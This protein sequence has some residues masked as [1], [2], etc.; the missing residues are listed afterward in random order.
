MIGNNQDVLG[1]NNNATLQ[2]QQME[3]G[4][5]YAVCRNDESN[6][7]V[8][9]SQHFGQSCD[10]GKK[11]DRSDRCDHD[12]SLS[13][14][15]SSRLSR[16]EEVSSEVNLAH[17]EVSNGVSGNV[18]TVVKERNHVSHDRSGREV[19]DRNS[20]TDLQ[21][22]NDTI[23][24]SIDMENG[25]HSK[26]E[27]VIILAELLLDSYNND[28]DDDDGDKILDANKTGCDFIGDDKKREL[29]LT[30]RHS[31]ASHQ[32]RSRCLVSSCP[33]TPD[34]SKPIYKT[35]EN[36]V[37]RR[38]E[39]VESN[40][41][42]VMVMAPYV[43]QSQ[44][45]DGNGP[46]FIDCH[47]LMCEPQQ[48]HDQNNNHSPEESNDDDE[49]ESSLTAMISAEDLGTYVDVDRNYVMRKRD[50]T[51]CHEICD[52][53][54]NDTSNDTCDQSYVR[55]GDRNGGSVDGTGTPR[56]S[57]HPKT[58]VRLL[59]NDT[60]GKDVMLAA[61]H[62]ES[63]V[64]ESVPL[65]Y[66]SKVDLGNKVHNSKPDEAYTTDDNNNLSGI[67]TEEGYVP[68]KGKVVVFDDYYKMNGSYCDSQ[69]IKIDKK[70][71]CRISEGK[72]ACSTQTNQAMAASNTKSITTEVCTPAPRRALRKP[73]EQCKKSKKLSILKTS[74]VTDAYSR[75]GYELKQVL[76]SLALDF[77]L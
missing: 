34:G 10:I 46:I 75:P 58:L 24:K 57:H 5:D 47:M 66:F 2:Q 18:E 30:T 14:E 65:G 67:K 26:D 31:D 15:L 59:E 1:D 64:D 76:P 54:C 61:L 38:L 40:S 3:L 43:L 12:G 6:S 52:Q 73:S 20:S 22:D 25:C 41:S 51:I 60:F 53:T 48:D 32:D 55:L 16:E 70:N 69:Q 28:D 7:V 23:V 11:E 21:E 27:D 13:N 19:C 71:S 77:V 29:A 44:I 39:S 50:T 9:E 17:D 45:I 62:E 74:C 42:E 4:I 68:M 49:M 36:Q 37:R 63:V 72:D 8:F 35:Q 33:V 56:V